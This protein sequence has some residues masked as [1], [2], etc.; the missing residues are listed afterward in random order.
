MWP[1]VLP[2]LVSLR[3]E[4]TDHPTDRNEQPL[5][6]E[7]HKTVV[8]ARA[9]DLS[10]DKPSALGSPCGI[11]KRVFRSNPL[12]LPTLGKFSSGSPG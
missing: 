11:D 10:P 3:G 4:Q 8:A 2:R 1:L 6:W 12:E 9:V 7:S 5:T